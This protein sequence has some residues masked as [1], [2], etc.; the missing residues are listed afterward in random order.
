M[1]DQME[2][3]LKAL[4]SGILSVEPG[5]V[6]DESVVLLHGLARTDKSLVV[7]QKALE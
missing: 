3:G 4:L 6:A 2:N 5:D 7:L 1:G